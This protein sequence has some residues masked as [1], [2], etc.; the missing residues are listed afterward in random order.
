MEIIKQ[1]NT[2]S[3]E[4]CFEDLLPPN[5]HLLIERMEIDLGKFNKNN[6]FNEL[7]THLNHA[8]RVAL[9]KN[10]SHNTSITSEKEKNGQTSSSN[11]S[12]KSL[13]GTEISK[14]PETT[15]LFKGPLEIF[16]FFLEKGR[17]PNWVP[18]DFRFEEDWVEVLDGQQLIQLRKL[19][20]RSE[21]AILRLAS[22][23]SVSF[24][25]SL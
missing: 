8:L 24:I 21:Q 18:L 22:H 1:I 16:I 23:F 13:I 25:F 10:I 4:N 3:F 12:H 5:Q 2:T 9:K 6:L 20:E 14:T 17:L 15:S 19:I 7:G 11:S